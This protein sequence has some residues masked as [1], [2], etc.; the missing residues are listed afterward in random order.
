MGFVKENET[1]KTVLIY[2]YQGFGKDSLCVGLL[3]CQGKIAEKIGKK[4]II[5]K[6]QSNIRH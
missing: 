1:K 6:F 5:K 2:L 4:A 3:T